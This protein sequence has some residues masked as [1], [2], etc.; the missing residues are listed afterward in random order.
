MRK[1][2]EFFKAMQARLEGKS[3]KDGSASSSK[4]SC[5]DPP[6][7]TEAKQRSTKDWS[8]SASKPSCDDPPFATEA[9]QEAAP[10]EGK[11][12]KPSRKRAS[13]GE[14][15]SADTRPKKR[16]REGATEH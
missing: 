7:A 14:A 16:K 3:T 11:Q 15:E 5:D 10:H 12:P 13:P 6:F 4:P 1:K 2:K 9:K 8:A